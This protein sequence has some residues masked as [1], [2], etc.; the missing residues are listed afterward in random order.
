MLLITEVDIVSTTEIMFNVPDTVCPFVTL[1]EL[2][3]KLLF[4]RFLLR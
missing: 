1:G 4:L 3:R 2:R